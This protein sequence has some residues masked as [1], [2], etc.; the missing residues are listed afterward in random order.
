[1]MTDFH[2]PHNAPEAGDKMLG[3]VLG[4]N[5]QV[6]ASGLTVRCSAAITFFSGLETSWQ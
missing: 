3:L 5:K 2:L 6:C 4:E 1:M